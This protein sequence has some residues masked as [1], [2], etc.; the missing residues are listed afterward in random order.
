MYLCLSFYCSCIS[1]FTLYLFVCFY[2][3]SLSLHCRCIS[4]FKLFLLSLC[5]TF[6]ITYSLCLSFA[7][8][9]PSLCLSLY[10]CLSDSIF[11]CL[12]F[13][14]FPFLSLFLYLSFSVSLSLVPLSIWGF[15][16]KTA[17]SREIYSHISTSK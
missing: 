13:S 9:P 11:P 3:F 5:L 17:D 8:F 15:S 7:L 1:L 6:S 12:S 10:L 2:S 14:I 4:I 16:G